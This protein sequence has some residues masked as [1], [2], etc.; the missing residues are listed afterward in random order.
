M[1]NKKRAVA[2][3]TV[4]AFVLVMLFSVVYIAAESDHDCVG[5]DCQICYQISV[6]QH[7]LRSILLIA[8]SVLSTAAIVC[9]LCRWVSRAADSS[10]F[11]TLVSLKVK[12]SD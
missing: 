7:T 11:C 5:S 3:L 9:V 4:A 8:C 10:I 1:T 6:C 12:L 2:F